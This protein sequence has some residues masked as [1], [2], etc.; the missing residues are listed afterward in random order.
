MLP[1]LSISILNHI[2]I[3]A[4]LGFI[5]N[6]TLFF[7][8]SAICLFIAVV[9]DFY[10]GVKKAKILKEK[11]YSGGFRKSI[12]KFIEYVLLFIIAITFDIVIAILWK[13]IPL[14]LII[15][16]IVAM[17]IECHSIFNENLK[18]IKSNS[19]KAFDIIED[20]VKNPDEIIDKINDIKDALNDKD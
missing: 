7:G 5:V 13:S 17:S 8:C 6:E 4:I 18:S 15:C 14:G 11:I 20:V 1:I 3:E 19:S 10:T 9:I 16:L 2:N 12:S